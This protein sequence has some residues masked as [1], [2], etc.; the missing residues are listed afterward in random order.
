LSK[1]S[2]GSY[3]IPI[4]DEEGFAQLRKAQRGGDSASVKPLFS[5]EFYHSGPY[6][7]PWIQTELVAT[8]AAVILWWSAYTAKNKLTA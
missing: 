1:S 5:L 6:K 3:S 4:Y 2:S 7:G 8:L